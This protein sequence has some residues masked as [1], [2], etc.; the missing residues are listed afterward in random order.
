MTLLY[1]YLLFEEIYLSMLFIAFITA[2]LSGVFLIIVAIFISTLSISFPVSA[3]F[4]FGAYTV[5]SIFAAI[6]RI[7]KFSP[8]YLLTISNNIITGQE[9]NLTIPLLS[10]LI[11]FIILIIATIKIF[12]KQEI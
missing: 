11:L 12:N 1:T 10:T 2:W 9:V 7:N 6:P 4:T 3:A 5:L 8:S